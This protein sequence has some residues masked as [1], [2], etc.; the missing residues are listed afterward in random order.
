MCMYVCVH[1][2]MY[3]MCIHARVCVCSYVHVH[4]CVYVCLLM[5]SIVYLKDKVQILNSHTK[6]M[7]ILN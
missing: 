1:E 4:L 2:G 3:E 5:F 6:G 7:C